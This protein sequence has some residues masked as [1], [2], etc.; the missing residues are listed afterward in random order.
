MNPK[1]LE[2]LISLANT[3]DQKGLR[4][5]AD[6]L[7][8]LIRTAELPPFLEKCPNCTGAMKKGADMCKKCKEKE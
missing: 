1:F 6:M 4:A 2:E 3:L 7:D 8:K 5:E